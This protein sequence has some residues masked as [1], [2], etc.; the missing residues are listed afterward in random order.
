M[1]DIIVTSV[2]QCSKAVKTSFLSSS[3][4]IESIPKVITWLE[5]SLTALKPCDTDV[6]IISIIKDYISEVI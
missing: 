3:V 6:T 2:S 4:G 1:I 5:E